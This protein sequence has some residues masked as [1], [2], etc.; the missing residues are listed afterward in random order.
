[1]GVTLSSVE[2]RSSSAST[3]WDSL[4]KKTTTAKSYPSSKLAMTYLAFELQRRTGIKTAAV[5]PGFV[6]SDI[7]RYL[8]G[9]KATAQQVM[10]ATIC[11]TPQQG[12]QTSVW[13]AS[14]EELP[15]GPVYVSPYRIFDCCPL[16]WDAVNVYNGPAP[17]HAAKLA[18]DTKQAGLLFAFSRDAVK[19]H[20][21]DRLPEELQ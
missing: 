14:S 21:P 12:C 16:V 1:M 5:N 20:L 18:Y 2:H 9:W 7:W 4:A 8:R 10:N 11:L 6:G 13:A 17:C 19:A 15:A 3:N